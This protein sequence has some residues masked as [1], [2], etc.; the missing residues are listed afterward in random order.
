MLGDPKHLDKKH[1]Q[2][3]A[4][5][6]WRMP[7]AAPGAGTS[8]SK[9][10]QSLLEYSDT[11]RPIALDPA[12]VAQARSTILRASIPQI[13]FEQLRR[14]YGDD[15]RALQLDVIAGVGIE[16]V[17]RRKSGRR[18]SEPVPAFYTQGGVQRGTRPRHGAR[19]SNSS[20]RRRG[21][22]ARARCPPRPG[23][24]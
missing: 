20:P 21:S 22:G 15:K 16:K 24:S 19:W 8:L 11:L 1:L 12:L 3:L 18:L 23:A 6:E 13:M 14:F 9:H 5:L 10:F 17:L 7:D 2:F 4:D